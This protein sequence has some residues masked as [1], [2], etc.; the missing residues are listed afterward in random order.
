VTLDE[1]A[2]AETLSDKLQIPLH[3]KV[4]DEPLDRCRLTPKEALR[5][6][7]LRTDGRRDS[8]LKGRA[9]LKKLLARWEETEE[10]ADISFPNSRLS[11]T[12]SGNYAVAVGTDSVTL[13]GVGVDLEMKRSVRPEAA[14]F[15]L[16]EEE[17]AW[18]IRQQGTVRAEALPRL[19]TTKEA[20][21]KADCDNQGMGLADYSV[22]EPGDWSGRALSG[23]SSE[24]EFRYACLQLE[25]GVLSV[26]ILLR[27]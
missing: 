25:R 10:T 21:F 20:I 12:H 2:L 22:E 27:R 24:K 6:S 16:T 3:V 18:V 13:L 15:F 4:S 11:L 23:G 19:W 26:A 17:Q 5:Y 7:E 9:A 14:R 8:W 1:E